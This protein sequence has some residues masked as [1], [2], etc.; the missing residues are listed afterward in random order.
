LKFITNPQ[1]SNL[2]QVHTKSFKDFKILFFKKPQFLKKNFYYSM[3]FASIISPGNLLNFQILNSLSFKNK[4]KTFNKLYVKQSYMLLTWI[5]YLQNFY[6]KK[7]KSFSNKKTIPSFFFFPKNQKKITITK[8]PMAH[9]T[10]SQEQYLFK[11]YTFSVS[12]SIPLNN[13]VNNNNTN[14][15]SFD[16]SLFFLLKQKNFFDLNIGTNLF[17]LKKITFYSTWKSKLFFKFF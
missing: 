2:K 13:F 14:F 16:A 5:S 9:K 6:N 4:K 7:Q 12:Y 8:A 10:F 17:F 1:P 15:N 3:K 11:F